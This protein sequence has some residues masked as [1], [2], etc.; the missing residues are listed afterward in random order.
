MKSFRFFL[1]ITCILTCFSPAFASNIPQII[2]NGKLIYFAHTII[3]KYKNLPVQNLNKA[4]NIESR[5]SR[6]LKDYNV[7]SVAQTFSVENSDARRIGL[8]K[9]MTINYSKD[10]DPVNAAAKIRELQYIE[11]AEPKYIRRIDFV[12]DDSSYNSTEQWNLFQINAQQAWDVSQGDTS[13]IVG[14][15]DTGVDWPHPDLRANMWYG[16]GYDLGGLNGTP[17]NNPI[18]DNPYHG[19]FVAGVVSAVTNNKIGIASI[20]FKTHLM[21][22]KAAREDMKDLTTG[23]PYIIYGFEGIVYAAD[24]GAKVINCSWGGGGYSNMEQEVIYYALSKGALVVA[25]AGNDNLKEDFYPASYDGVLSV[26]ATSSN[27]IK[28]SFSNFGYFVDV[29]APGQ[30]IYSTWQPNTYT[31]ASGTSFSTPLVSG[32]AGLVFAHFPGY[33]PLQV[34]E[35]IRVNSDNIDSQNSGYQNLLGYGRIDAYKALNNTNSVSIRAYDIQ[36]SDSTQGGNGDGN[37][38]PGENVEVRI[39]LKNYLNPASNVSI[40]L[41]SLNNYITV[42]NGSYNLGN[43]GTLDSADNYS[44]PFIIKIADNVPYNDTIALKLNYSADN[45]NDYQFAVA[46]VNNTF[47]TQSSNDIIVTI[48]SQ[49]NIGFNDYPNNLEGDGFKF[50]NGSNL[51]F[52]G[53]LM[54]GTS[55]VKLSD[56]ARDANGLGKDTSF[57]IIDPILITDKP[58]INLA[59]E[60]GHTIFNDNGS[61]ANKLGIT[62]DLHSYSFNDANNK[63]SVILNYIFTNTTGSDISNFYSGLFFDWD[64]VEGSGD[65]DIVNYDNTGNLGYAYHLGRNPDTYVGTALISSDNYGFW[66]IANGGDSQFQIYDGFS[67]AEKWQTL[68]SGIGKTSAGPTDISEVTSA[69]PFSIPAGKYVNVAFVMAAGSN[70]DELR[71]SVSNARDIYNNQLANNGGGVQI[72]LTYSLSQNY[73][74]PFNPGTKIDYEIPDQGRVTIKVYDILGQL[75]KTLVN[76]D[77]QPG[78]YTLQFFPGSL[79][80]GIYFYQLKVNTFTSTKKLVILK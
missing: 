50:M 37:L 18:E 63:N 23:L 71:A 75:V 41:Q 64:L 59:S 57:Q 32:L 68:S 78:K 55:P 26:A 29:S 1:I 54:F 42:E 45:Y 69:G 19:T 7:E 11:W 60:E 66:A 14:I 79:A 36:F 33:S 21:A 40:S 65:S 9:I 25:A 30:N 44:N 62:V 61:G 49:G 48:T 46:P 2:H 31:H 12:P 38:Q 47:K 76:E 56:E 6:L 16:I 58:D 77:K 74:N 51:L 52:E 3:I 34:A 43:I 20:G 13:V 72:P 5:I 22:V 4:S 39:K 67:N 28:A 35:Q 80:S 15:V 70:L 8:D 53:A 73:P 17:D 27:D 10:I 24:H